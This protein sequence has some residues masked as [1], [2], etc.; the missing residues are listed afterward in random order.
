MKHFSAFAIT[1]AAALAP[2]A[3]TGEGSNAFFTHMLGR[4]YPS[5]ESFACFS[6][7]YDEAAL[8][9]HPD[10]NVTFAKVLA[11]ASY[12]QSASGAK[13]D[14]YSIELGL[15]F[16]FRGR[17]ETLTSAASCG[18]ARAGETLHDGASCAGPV[19]S[20]G[21]MRLALEGADALIMTIPNGS[22]LWG[23]GPIDQRHDVIKNPFGAD[24][25]IFR[26]HRTDVSHCE[27]LAFDRQKPLR[28]HEP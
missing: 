18:G 12:R 26:L 25:K 7:R 15:A 16:R 13:P 21:H 11:S 10:Q 28:P 2:V 3:A 1:A 20:A 8:A 27:D 19:G 14:A 6:R 5:G 17:A 24:D 9:A 4:L 22:D 23:P